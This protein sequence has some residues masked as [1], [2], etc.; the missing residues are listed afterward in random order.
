MLLP[1]HSKTPRQPL[2]VVGSGLA[3]LSAAL[4]AADSGSPVT[5]VTANSLSSGSSWW[6]QGGI[7]AAV[8][9]DDRP[10]YHAADTLAVG[11]NL[12]DRHAVGVLV[13][14]G[15]RAAMSLLRSGVQ[16]EGGLNDPDLGLEA[17][18]GHRRI[19]HAEG[20]ATGEM[21]SAALLARAVSHERIR[22]V[23]E[24]PITSLLIE[25]GRVTGVVG[26]G[27]SILGSAVIIAT[28]GYAGLWGRSTNP[29]GNRGVGLYLALQAGATL[30]DLEFV[31]FHPTAL[32]V[33]GRPAYLLS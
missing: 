19:L 11:A 13:H 14:E 16:F 17:G 4:A 15:R 30:A 32:N 25:D 28:G 6:A 1:S 31:Q 5:L 7:A 33:Q 2:I 9:R 3:G 23:P 26:R 12:N 22:L 21:V 20:G 29:Q 10:S 18:H 8:G 24:T 27:E